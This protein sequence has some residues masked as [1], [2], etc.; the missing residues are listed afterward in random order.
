MVFQPRKELLWQFREEVSIRCWVPWQQQR[1]FEQWVTEQA[2]Y[3]YDRSVWNPR[4]HILEIGQRNQRKYPGRTAIDIYCPD[5]SFKALVKL[6]W[7]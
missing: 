6:T 3:H 1:E 5:K 7:G 4:E 2:A